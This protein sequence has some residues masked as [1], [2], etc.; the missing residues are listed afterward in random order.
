LSVIALASVDKLESYHRPI[1]F[2]S[3][4]PRASSKHPRALSVLV[5]ASLV[6]WSLTLEQE[7]RALPQSLCGG[8]VLGAKA[9][10]HRALWIGFLRCE[11]VRGARGEGDA[12][13]P[14]RPE[15]V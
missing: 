10:C 15:S 13:T 7:L 1:T 5:L 12:G 8:N 3:F 9:L 11:G 14:I 4:D 2:A 6:L